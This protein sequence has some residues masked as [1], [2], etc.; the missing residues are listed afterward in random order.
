[1][2]P[3]VFPVFAEVPRRG[4]RPRPGTEALT[5]AS[6]DERLKDDRFGTKFERPND[7][8]SKALA[9][10]P[11]TQLYERPSPT[12]HP[13]WSVVTYS[14]NGQ[15]QTLRLNHALLNW[16]CSQTNT[17]QTIEGGD[18]TGR[19]VSRRDI[20]R[21]DVARRDVSWRDVAIRGGDVIFREKRRRRH[22]V[23]KHTNSA[24]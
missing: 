21:R 22:R 2:P 18:V 24:I 13:V 12:R 3:A 17:F 11:F 4:G 1:V 16:F 15:L 8:Y 23:Q 9:R 19:D 5:L 6:Q 10:S 14:C 20:A 7:G